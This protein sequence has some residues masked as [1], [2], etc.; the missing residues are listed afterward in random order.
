AGATA[1]LQ[2][3]ATAITTNHPEVHLMVVLVDGRPEEVTDWQRSVQGEVIAS[4]FDRPAADHTSVAELAIDAAKRLVELGLSYVNLPVSL[5]RLA[6]AYNAAA[7]PSGRKLVTGVDAGALYPPKRIFGA[8]RNVG[9]GG[10]LTIVATASVGTGSA[11]DEAIFEERSEEHTSELQ[12][13]EN[14][15]CR[16][17]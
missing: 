3:L 11:V 12:S 9:N 10:S 14:L 15:V 4:P 7:R 16:L 1:T 17:L 13:R 2:Q 6:R 5:P 8:A